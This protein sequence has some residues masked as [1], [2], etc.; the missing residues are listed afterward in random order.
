MQRG[1]LLLLAEPLTEPAH[2]SGGMLEMC[3]GGM[4]CRVTE[5]TA[6]VRSTCERVDAHSGTLLEC[7]THVSVQP[8]TPL[9]RMLL[10]V[11]IAALA[12]QTIGAASASA[13][14][15]GAGVY[16]GAGGGMLFF[17][18]FQI[19]P[20]SKANGQGY[21]YLEEICINVTKIVAQNTRIY[22]KVRSSSPPIWTSTSDLS[23][24]HP[25]SIQ[26]IGSW[27]VSRAGAVRDPG[28]DA[29][30]TI[31]TMWVESS[32]SASGHLTTWSPRG[33][34][35]LD[36]LELKNEQ[37]V[38]N[39]AGL[40]NY[41]PLNCQGRTHPMPC[42]VYGLGYTGVGFTAVSAQSELDRTLM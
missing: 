25:S 15:R 10:L 24:F 5:C 30:I 21:I 41:S 17:L 40:G 36:N 31:G 42:K 16:G 39:P 22:I 35:F 29:Y 8:K 14:V 6:S 18:L 23:I 3:R 11:F 1:G 19:I 27:D 2:E 13:S 4:R 20:W 9:A 33:F 26:R 34:Y 32:W 28:T 12:T 37:Q 7:L 38:E